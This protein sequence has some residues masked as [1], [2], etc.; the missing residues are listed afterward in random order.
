MNAQDA[1]GTHASVGQGAE[2]AV[3]AAEE[4]GGQPAVAPHESHGSAHGEPVC[5]YC[6]GMVPTAVGR[7]GEVGT[8][9]PSCKGLLDALSIQA[10]RGHMGEWFIRDEAAPFRPGCSLATLRALIDRGRVGAAS[11]VRGPDTE[12]FWHRAGHVPRI[13]RLMGICPECQFQVAHG[14]HE[15][16]SCGTGL[17][18]LEEAMHEGVRGSS[19]H[20]GGTGADGH[21]VQALAA[22]VAGAP[23]RSAAAEIAE[24]AVKRQMQ[25]DV[26]MWARRA[27]LSIGIAGFLL[28]AV[29]ALATKDMW[30]TRDAGLATGGAGLAPTGP[31][32][33]APASTPTVDRQAPAPEPSV[34]PDGGAK[35]APDA[36]PVGDGPAGEGSGEDGAGGDRA[37]GDR[38]AA[39]A[40]PTRHGRDPL[41]AQI[42]PLMVQ[43]TDESL[44]EAQALL[45]R[46]I[47][48]AG[49]ER[50]EERAQALA[51]RDWIERRLQ[52]RELN[53]LP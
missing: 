21:G 25:R 43:D 19:W 3:E 13:A 2:S 41:W 48:T 26:K 4:R 28:L 30:W 14:A 52:A 20:A 49:A 15:C 47:D 40:A 32:V 22:V 46:I 36:A 38:S 9:C 23:A 45:Q 17:M 51:T 18:S 53:A 29:I 35:P 37:G 16:A 10:T 34:T 8:R 33:P 11:V 1:N 42:T 5:P 6:G 24:A 7:I 44:R 27:G 31:V 50:A 12:Q 39:P